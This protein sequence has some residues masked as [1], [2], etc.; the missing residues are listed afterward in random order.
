ML[1]LNWYISTKN[2]PTKEI[3]TV[4]IQL[5]QMH[6]HSQLLKAGLRKQEIKHCFAKFQELT[7]NETEG[8]RQHFVLNARRDTVIMPSGNV[9]KQITHSTGSL[10]NCIVTSQDL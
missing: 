7:L 5:S 9:L 4:Y 10:I 6:V 1:R 8:R 3:G 2:R